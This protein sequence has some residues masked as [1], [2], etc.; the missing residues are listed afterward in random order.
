MSFPSD[1]YDDEGDE[2]C[3]VIEKEEEE[4]NVT[5]TCTSIF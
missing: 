5:F 3:M 4:E 1:R 2:R